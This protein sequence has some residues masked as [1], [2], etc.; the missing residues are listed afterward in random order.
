MKRRKALFIVNSFGA[1]GAERVCVTLSDAF[2]PE[3]ECDFITLYQAH[4]YEP[5]HR[6]N[7]FCL[8][9]DSGDSAT[10]KV[11]SLLP[12]VS[13]INRFIKEREKERQYDIVTSHLPMAHVLTRYSS[14]SK[15]ALYVMHGAQQPNDPNRSLLFNRYLHAIYSDRTIVCV[16]QGI[17]NELMQRYGF[18]SDHLSVIYNPVVIKQT[19]EKS[20][21]VTA[22]QPYI[23]VASR[24]SEIKRIDRAI[25]VF[26]NGNFSETHKLV[27]LGEGEKREELQAIVDNANM[28]GKIVFQGF[29]KD[30]YIW[31]KHAELFL[32]TSDSE[33][34][35]MA[36]AEALLCGTPVVL[37]DC[38]F[39]PREILVGDLKEYLV[40]PVDSIDGYI[41]AI[42]KVIENKTAYPFEEFNQIPL[43]P[44][45]VIKKYLDLARSITSS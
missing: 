10:K 30:P 43:E 23:L 37:S 42:R 8:M 19:S 39:G 34:F 27:I 24:L 21:T 14:V 18:N 26:I 9:L 4:D 7:E 33:S 13:K 6:I 3:W 44:Q 45:I 5:P 17:A 31:M 36:P 1:G 40:S 32:S 11:V 41:K 25:E 22:L 15:R 29:Q 2:G 16:S 35:G 38:D 28:N 12:L 20:N